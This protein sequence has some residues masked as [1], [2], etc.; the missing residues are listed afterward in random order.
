MKKNAFEKDVGGITFNISPMGTK[1]S[2]VVK[3]DAG[4][5]AKH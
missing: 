5:L 3:N 1:I 2:A 4:N